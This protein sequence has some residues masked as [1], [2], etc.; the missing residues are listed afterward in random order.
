MRSKSD[1]ENFL[2]KAIR[3]GIFLTLF[4]P[5]V[6]G[7]FGLSFSEFPKS[8]YFRVLTE[9][10]FISYLILLISGGRQYLPKVKGR[11]IV[12]AVSFFIAVLGLGTLLSVNPDWSFWGTIGRSL[13]FVTYLHFFAF[14]LVLV[15]TVKIKEDW[16]FLLQWTVFVSGIASVAGILQK[17]NIAS[18][19]GVSL[20]ER[21]SGTLAN[22][23]FFGSYLVLNIFLG[24]FLLALRES[25]EGVKVA[26][27][28]ITVL[29]LITL[30]LSGHRAGWIGAA[31]GFAFL[32]IIWFWRYSHQNKILKR[33]FI[34][35]AISL[36]IAT[37]LLFLNREG[38]S[39]SKNSTLRRVVSVFYIEDALDNRFFIWKA[40][41]KGWKEKPILGWGLETSAFVFDKHRNIDT[42]V[43]ISHASSSNII[44][45]RPHNKILEVASDVGLIGVF[46]YLFLFFS[47]FYLLIKYKERWGSVP[48][49]ILSSLF[50]AYFVQNLAGFDT[51]NTYSVFFLLLGF[52]SSNFF[53]A[54]KEGS[55]KKKR[56][57]K[58]ETKFSGPLQELAIKFTAV[59]LILLSVAVFYV[60]NLRL[61]EISLEAIRAQDLEKTNLSASLTN[62]EE[63]TKKKT[64]L[65]LDIRWDI[66]EKLLL[67][68]EVGEL[69]DF[70][71]RIVEILSGLTPDLEADLAKPIK[72]YLRKHLLMSRTYEVI[73][74]IAGDEEAVNRMEETAERMREF[75]EN[76]PDTYW[77]LGKAQIYRGNYEE[78]EVLF[79]KVI[80]IG[81]KETVRHYSNLAGTYIYIGDK[82][83]AGEFLEKLVDE[84]YNFVKRESPENISGEKLLWLNGQ[85]RFI[86]AAALFHVRDLNDPETAIEIYKKAIFI[87]PIYKEV[88]QAKID[89]L[90][91]D[92]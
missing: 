28:S 59:L 27:A 90:E 7:R 40:I 15:S 29:N 13:G 70:R 21:I 49:L 52:V 26:L 25:K 66:T 88:L 22:P 83:K 62:Y 43:D 81:F 54:E 6:I 65:A 60:L 48:T 33:I 75:N 86:D 34:L 42:N 5:L 67:M 87:Y 36:G 89:A 72:G 9:F 56:G 41:V 68:L 74:L 64:V 23:D 37:S 19:Y 14:F 47:I 20:P 51:I 71:P 16:I 69:R 84:V 76:Y 18:F 8:V 45:D 2:L 80:K 24:L 17:L 55:T 30:L 46:S 73:F 85:Q 91:E 32:G 31:A 82:A 3:I 61:L 11:L 12:F 35:V 53:D 10:I 78:G 92:L 79:E 50:I 58:T 4:T 1:L 39:S 38:L 77:Y 63:I 57:N 44:F